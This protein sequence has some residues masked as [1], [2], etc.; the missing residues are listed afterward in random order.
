M[1]QEK[2]CIL[3]F[4]TILLFYWLKAK[5]T[6]RRLCTFFSLHPSNSQL[7]QSLHL[8]AVE[9]TTQS[10]NL[11]TL[12]SRKVDPR[13]I[14]KK[15]SWWASSAS[16]ATLSS[17]RLTKSKSRVP[18]TSSRGFAPPSRRAARPNSPPW[19]KEKLQTRPLVFLIRV[20]TNISWR[21]SWTTRNIPPATRPGFVA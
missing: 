6:E 19:R 11:Q 10:K 4:F 3:L 12:L 21:N 20:E 5:L 18:D 7:D 9:F 16:H 17:S 14:C 8:W 2:N 1:N 15:S 13:P